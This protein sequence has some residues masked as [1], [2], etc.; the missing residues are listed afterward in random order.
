MSVVATEQPHGRL[1]CSGPL[2]TRSSRSRLR[3]GCPDAIVHLTPGLRR[4][5]ILVCYTGNP[6]C[7]RKLLSNISA[8]T[9]RRA[10]LTCL[11]AFPAV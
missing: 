6:N 11:A 3:V 7:L 5:R 8:G 9:N 2:P 1:V 10:K 4:G